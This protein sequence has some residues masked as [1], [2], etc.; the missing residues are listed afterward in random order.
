MKN[1]LLTI[2]LLPFFLFSCNKPVIT[3]SE[4]FSNIQTK[5]I[6]NQV[7]YSIDKS[8]DF[9]DTW[10]KSFWS[11]FQTL[12]ERF[13]ALQVPSDI[14]QDM[15][16]EALAYSMIHYP[17]N[18]LIFA[19]D[20]PF[21]FIK[22]VLE[23]SL[24]H[25]E[26][27]QRSEGLETLVSL[28]SETKIVFERDVYNGIEVSLS[29][30]VFIEYF[31][32]YCFLEK[33]ISEEKR[34]GLLEV[35]ENKLDERQNLPELYS[36]LSIEPLLILQ[37][38]LEE[39]MPLRAVYF[40][41][42]RT[43]LNQTV[44]VLHRDEMTEAEITQLNNDAVTM[45]PSAVF[46]SSA[47]SRYNCH[48]YAWISTASTNDKWLNATNSSG[49]FQLSKYWTNDLFTSCSSGAEINIFYTNG[50]HSAKKSS[51]SGKYISKWGNW[52]VMEHTVLP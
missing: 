5:G 11:R 42:Y 3:R 38:V 46:V 43:P 47:S 8:Y 35:T 22:L 16:A 26:I 45:Y 23:K 25:Q 27:L 28:Y 37:R 31:F 19:Y 29:D 17:L 49:V 15:T 51:S 7:R 40:H 32:S 50:D 33:Q 48:S 52:P 6:V 13:N 21:V 39:S 18:K 36:A 44:Q 41:D 12:E 24:L 1:I 30:E 9:G 14:L 4:S 34:M 2:V 20:N 10:S